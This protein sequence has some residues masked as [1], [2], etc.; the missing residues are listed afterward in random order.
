MKAPKGLTLDLPN[1]LDHGPAQLIGKRPYNSLA[2]DSQYAF[3][4]PY[5]RA[6]PLSSFP[7]YKQS[8]DF[9]SYQII[10]RPR[11]YRSAESQSSCSS[12]EKGMSATQ[13]VSFGYVSSDKQRS[14]E[15]TSPKHSLDL[16]SLSNLTPN[17]GQDLSLP[18]ILSEAKQKDD[19]EVPCKLI[20]Y[21]VLERIAKSTARAQSWPQ[22]YQDTWGFNVSRSAPELPPFYRSFDSLNSMPHTRHVRSN[23]DA[24]DVASQERSYGNDDLVRYSLSREQRSRQHP[25]NYGNVRTMQHMRHYPEYSESHKGCQLTADRYDTRSHIDGYEPGSS[26]LHPMS[27]RLPSD[28]PFSSSYPRST[29]DSLSDKRVKTPTGYEGATFRM[30]TPPHSKNYPST[31]AAKQFELPRK[32]F[33]ANTPSKPVYY[34]GK[35]TKSKTGDSSPGETQPKRGG[36]LPKPITDMLKTWLLEHAE[37]PYPTEEEKRRFCEYTGLDICQISNWFVNAR[38]RILAPQ[39]Q[40]AA[41]K[42]V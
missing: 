7:P 33:P 17:E 13:P 8:N 2:H 40:A 16:P 22:L 28:A 42:A 26:H 11:D 9:D 10:P 39:I 18:Q 30:E 1:P 15:N 35:G 23:S 12:S 41:G 24:Y 3:A 31:I 32:P 38:R 34:R 21:S 6:G 27:H 19:K 25:S 36:K 14:A 37:H 5:D 4:T 29:R 20:P